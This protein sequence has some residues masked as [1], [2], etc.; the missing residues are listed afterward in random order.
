MNSPFPAQQSV[1]IPAIDAVALVRG[2]AVVLTPQG[3]IMSVTAET[4]A[5]R[6]HKKPVLVCHAPYVSQRL[7]LEI[8][9]AFDVLELYAFIHPS[10]FTVPTIQGVC[11][12]LA[13]V[14]GSD[15]DDLPM[16]LQDITTKLL[17]DFANLP[18]K[19]REQALKMA[20][21]MEQVWPWT[22]FLFGACGEKYNADDKPRAPDYFNVWHDLK[23]WSETIPHSD[24]SYLPVTGDE[25]R[26]QLQTLLSRK[27]QAEARQPQVDYATAMTGMFAPKQ[28][29]GHPSFILAE[30]GTGVGKTLGYLSPASV[31]AEKND[32]SVTIS[33]YTKNLQR[34]IGQELKTLYPDEAEYKSKAAIRKGRE[35]YL[36]LLNF[37]EEITRG[38]LVNSYQELVAAGIMA[39]WILKTESGDLTGDDFPGWL[40]G[41][42]GHSLTRALADK[43]GECIYGA[44][45]HYSR[46]FSEKSV[47]K[48]ENARIVVANHAL[49]MIQAALAD[50]DDLTTKHFIFDEGHHLF[51]AADN[52]FAAHL[53]A[54]EMA[55][56]RRWLLGAEGGRKRRARGLSKKL[57][58]FTESS[59][60]LNRILSELRMAA[61]KLPSQDWQAHLR[62]KN[63]QN[64]A[65]EF[66]QK[67]SQQVWARENGKD[68]SYSLETPVHPMVE[69]LFDIA[70]QL[71]AD[72]LAIQKPMNELTGALQNMLSDPEKEWSKEDRQ[73]LQSVLTSIRRRSSSQMAAWI[74]FL[75]H[76]MKGITPPEFVDWFE[77]S[78]EEGR[79]I[80]VGAFRHWV[81]PLQGF[82]AVMRHKAHGVGITSASLRD[83]KDWL[84]AFRR[85]GATYFSAA[86]SVF[87]AQSPFNYV[88]NSK[89]LIVTDVPRDDVAQ[90][91]SAY[92]QLFEASKGGA[93]GVFTSIQRLR[94]VCDE[95]RERLEGEDLTLYA[96]HVDP[97]DNGT[98]IDMFRADQHACLLGTDAVRDGVDVP[99]DSLRLLVF[100]RVPWPRATILHKAR[101]NLFGR[102]AYNEMLT[103]LKLKQAFGRLIRKDTDRGIF[104]MLEQQMPSRLL[105]AFPEGV[106]VKRCGLSEAVQEIKGFF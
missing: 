37:A 46:C 31:Y 39:R 48:A 14:V 6:L 102:D 32:A 91:A 4:A 13:L 38:D 71:R 98:L 29:E 82:A 28:D 103:R 50:E 61:Q 34:Q 105:T 59:E 68:T 60:K 41:L 49:V 30:A 78:R 101:S 62:A 74:E 54:W 85:T 21:V 100:D 15:A 44:C 43:K 76:I 64:K 94:G 58:G 97:I 55:E 45:P 63:P 72:F 22:Q 26:A 93:L 19:E 92:Q 7:G 1:N 12:A 89:V 88:E 17:T 75:D 95:M 3:E 56:L 99:G 77:M 69:G 84:S 35:N 16:A 5:L 2:A 52:A 53:S 20:A 40:T 36:C 23:E 70:Q 80:D 65:E 33:T 18:Q 25:A 87:A 79:I 104:V 27:G 8:G 66:L 67:I 86:P 81:D 9:T 90:R 10:R 57:E 83:E 24:A 51:E 106:E 73:R 47:R 11:K 42:L 96:Q